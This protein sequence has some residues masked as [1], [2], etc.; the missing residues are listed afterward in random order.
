MLE[1]P[2]GTYGHPDVHLCRP[3]TFPNRLAGVDDVRTVPIGQIRRAVPL[4][5][6]A[7]RHPNKPEL[8]EMVGSIKALA[9]QCEPPSLP[10][11]A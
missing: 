4:L 11:A 1:V 8:Q 3:G 2:S 10:L 9:E 5:G 6:R 7:R